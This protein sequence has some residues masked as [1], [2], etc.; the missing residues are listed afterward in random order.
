MSE[1]LAISDEY[2][3][4]LQMILECERI[5]KQIKGFYLPPGSNHWFQ[6]YFWVLGTPSTV[7]INI[8]LEIRYVYCNIFKIEDS[9]Q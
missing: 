6:K 1:T 7:S 2:T 5:Q 4:I 3:T 9:L 8:V